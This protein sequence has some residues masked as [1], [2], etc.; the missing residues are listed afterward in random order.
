[1]AKFAAESLQFLIHYYT[2]QLQS[3]YLAPFKSF[4]VAQWVKN[5]PASAGDTGSIP[6]PGRSPE[7][8]NGNPLQF[9]CLEI[10]MDRGVWWATV[11]GVKNSQ[12]QRL[13]NN[14]GFPDGISDKESARQRKR[15]KK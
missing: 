12:T 2:L 3:F 15:Q 1:M 9:S 5:L 10:F 8:R 11:Q 13:N 4:L 7:E 14:F 6:D